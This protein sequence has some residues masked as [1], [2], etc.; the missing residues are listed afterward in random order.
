MAE[1]RIVRSIVM[2][3][4]LEQH[5]L[6]ATSPGG[7]V[8]EHQYETLRTP[9]GE[10]ASDRAN[11]KKN[12][13]N[14]ALRARKALEKKLTEDPPPA[15]ALAAP[16]E[17]PAVTERKKRTRL[18]LPGVRRGSKLAKLSIFE[19]ASVMM[20]AEAL[21][22]DEDELLDGDGGD[23]GSCGMGGWWQDP[24]EE[25]ETERLRREAAATADRELR[26]RATH[27]LRGHGSERLAELEEL[28]SHDAWQPVAGR[29]ALWRE[30]RLLLEAD[31]LLRSHLAA[32]LDVEESATYWEPPP[33]ALCGSLLDGAFDFSS[34]DFWC[35]PCA[36]ADAEEEERHARQAAAQWRRQEY[37]RRLREKARWRAPRRSHC[38]LASVPHRCLTPSLEPF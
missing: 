24:W 19:Q 21:D 17:L 23:G 26:V 5:T 28:L 37:E 7:R 20:E 35:E 32:P 9:D 38:V 15:A 8:R 16:P 1:P 12:N 2:D 31:P 11:R 22:C 18:L 4:T 25:S 14:R 3:K 34:G 29:G 27:E 10:T 30:H 36:K 6:Q 13:R 33:C